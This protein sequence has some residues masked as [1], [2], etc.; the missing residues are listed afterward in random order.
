MPP[1]GIISRRCA[2]P[3]SFDVI[4][5]TLGGTVR[6]LR[7]FRRA[8]LEPRCRAIYGVRQRRVVL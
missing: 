3:K 1:S 8:T 6:D 5:D 7:E 2:R 4:V